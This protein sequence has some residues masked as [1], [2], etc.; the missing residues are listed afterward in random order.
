MLALLRQ[1]ALTLRVQLREVRPGHDHPVQEHLQLGVRL[2]TDRLN[3]PLIAVAAG[4][5][6]QKGAEG[7]DVTLAQHLAELRDVRAVV[8]GHRRGSG[9]QPWFGQAGCCPDG[10]AYDLPVPRLPA[11]Q[12]GHLGRLE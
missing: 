3:L 6:F 5:R 8:G 2:G 12:A 11:E 4:L 10:A 1:P 7:R 9:G